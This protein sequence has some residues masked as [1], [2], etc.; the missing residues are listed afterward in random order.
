MAKLNIKFEETQICFELD[1][2]KLEKI[3]ENFLFRRARVH[4][5]K[6][7]IYSIPLLVKLFS[8]EI[9][10]DFGVTQSINL[11]KEDI[12]DTL[13]ALSIDSEKKIELQLGTFDFDSKS[14]KVKICFIDSKNIGKSKKTKKEKK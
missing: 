5:G 12:I 10:S 1:F 4:V 13:E 6:T 3:I 9:E 14:Q 8:R 7:I 11:K 2:L